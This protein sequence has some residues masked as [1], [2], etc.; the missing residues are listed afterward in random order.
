MT[1]A[2][3]EAL[4]ARIEVHPRLVEEAVW[5]ALRGHPERRAFDGEREPLYAIE[6]PEAR[7]AAFDRLHLDWFLRLGL[8]RTL[9][10]AIAELGA[11]LAT[12]GRFLVIPATRERD[13]AA[14]LFVAADT[15]R[16]VAVAIRP[17]V[18]ADAGRA[19]VLLRRELLH[20]ADMIDPEFR[21]EPRLPA[22]PAGPAQDRLL[23]D[24][25]RVLWSCSVDGRLAATGRAE[26]GARAARLADFRKVFG[27]IGALTEAGFT[28]IFDG[29]RPTHPDL[30]EMGADPAG[31]FA[32][33]GAEDRARGR[34][35]LCGF[36]T[37]DFEPNPGDLPAVSREAIRADFPD[38]HA[39]RPI[40]LQCAD[41]Y[42][43]CEMSD[44]A[45]RSLPGIDRIRDGGASAGGS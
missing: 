13:Q 30:V 37:H 41:L 24:R 34:C 3:G 40:C 16:S 11:A 20:I 5:A 39:G 44:A 15:A 18:L 43:D 29:S 38:W 4:D 22:Q 7:D 28:R 2:E 8:H 19:I 10:R 33:R 27:G 36:P 1:G 45:A 42:R 31:A 21:Y 25:Y 23:Q 32:G 26:A 14:D 9:D 35:A 12:V 6:P 17:E